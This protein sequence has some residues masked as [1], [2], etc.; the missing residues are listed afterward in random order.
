MIDR[1][2][3]L[4]PTTRNALFVHSQRLSTT[5]HPQNRRKNLPSTTMAFLVLHNDTDAS[6]ESSDAAQRETYDK[7]QDARKDLLGLTAKLEAFLFRQNDIVHMG[8]DLAVA[9][10]AKML[11]RLEWA[12]IDVSSTTGGT[13]GIKSDD[14][15]IDLGAKIRR[16]G[17]RALGALEECADLM[18]QLETKF[19][20]S[21]SERSQLE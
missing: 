16:C 20:G 17:K 14:G 21:E 1:V 19:V 15:V 2:G 18:A 8:H 13:S 7:L 11:Q 5:P 6:G 3:L 9:R 4:K 10:H 12:D